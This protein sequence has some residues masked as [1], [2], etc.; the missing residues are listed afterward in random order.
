MIALL[1]AGLLF[2]NLRPQ[3]E[4]D[5]ITRNEPYCVSGDVSIEELHIPTGAMCEFDP[6][7]D[8]ILRVTKG[9]VLV[10]GLLG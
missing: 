6:G 5:A 1:A 7:R 9:S 4:P 2:V 10:E 8:S 3:P